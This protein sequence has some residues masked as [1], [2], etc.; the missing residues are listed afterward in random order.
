MSHSYKIAYT[1]QFPVRFA[2]SNYNVMEPFVGYL[3]ASILCL[4][5][6]ALIAFRNRNRLMPVA[7]QIL[8][9]LQNT[10]KYLLYTNIVGRHRYLGPWTVA[11][12]LL[13]LLYISANVLGVVYPPIS[14]RGLTSRAG[15]V[16]LVNIGF[17]CCSL[18]VDFVAEIFGLTPMKWRHLHRAVAW[19]TGTLTTVHVIS[20]VHQGSTQLGRASYVG[21]ILGFVLIL[22]ILIASANPL[23]WWSGLLASNFHAL[24]A[25]VAITA[26]YTHIVVET[27]VSWKIF[28][29][30][31]IFT[32]T[33]SRDV[34]YFLYRNGM[35]SGKGWTRVSFIRLGDNTTQ[36]CLC[37][38]RPVHVYPGQYIKLWVPFSKHSSWWY[39]RQYHVQSW[40]PTAQQQLKLYDLPSGF[41][42][43]S[44]K[45]MLYLQESAPHRAFFTGPYGLHHEYTQYET[46]LIIIYDYGILSVYSQ[47]QYIY[48]C[49]ENRTSKARRLRLV[50][51]WDIIPKT[52]YS[53]PEIKALEEKIHAILN[54]FSQ[55]V[56]LDPIVLKYHLG[57]YTPPEKP[58]DDRILEGDLAQKRRHTDRE[59]LESAVREYICDEKSDPE[60]IQLRK[61]ALRHKIN[62]VEMQIAPLENKIEQYAAQIR[63]LDSVTSWINTKLKQKIENSP[64]ECSVYIAQGLETYSSGR[65]KT[66]AGT[67]GVRSIFEMEVQNHRRRIAADAPGTR[68]NFLLM[69]SGPP[70]V[71]DLVRNLTGENLGDVDLKEFQ[72]IPA[73]RF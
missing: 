60:N 19:M 12:V 51:Q 73:H 55:K 27:G 56:G 3:V 2:I 13:H 18:N 61:A 28:I 53:F 70:S 23:K 30:P 50:W 54:E 68:R 32:V 16:A 20:A 38:G 24:F 21:S 46:I 8:R 47:L 66:I 62:T 43:K 36:L 22:T 35:L 59:S 34:W 29:L 52:E 26:V 25:L 37:P 31:G 33:L 71:Q 45:K 44:Q 11:E 65:A 48:Y 67:A 7:Y 41:I 63:I 57:I 72:Y 9:I 6:V 17:L 64:I 49:I 4:C 39:F 69:V 40:E 58:E 42:S 15:A 14:V 10:W 5:V 1:I